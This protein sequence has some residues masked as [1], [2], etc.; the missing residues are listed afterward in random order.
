MSGFFVYLYINWFNELFLQMKTTLLLYVLIIFSSFNN[1]GKGE[2]KPLLLPTFSSRNLPIP[3]TVKKNITVM[4]EELNM[5]GISKFEDCK[6][7][8]QKGF[9]RIAES[10]TNYYE[11]RNPHLW[12]ADTYGI[13]QISY[14]YFP[15]FAS[16]PAPNKNLG[17]SYKTQVEV[18]KSMCREYNRIIKAIAN[19]TPEQFVSHLRKKMGDERINICGVYY[20]MHLSPYAIFSLSKSNKVGYSNGY[21]NSYKKLMQG[22]LYNKRFSSRG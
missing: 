9:F 8:L 3:P 4:L 2:I 20:S 5:D 19:M 13:F 18:M 6:T 15:K 10:E 21:T 17:Y 12:L 7:P 14:K 16:L 22:S 1:S 11:V